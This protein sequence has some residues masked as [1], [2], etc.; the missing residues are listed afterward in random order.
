[1]FFLASGKMLR[2]AVLSRNDEIWDETCQHCGKEDEQAVL[3]ENCPHVCCPR[4]FARDPHAE[5]A[6]VNETDYYCPACRG[7]CHAD[8]TRRAC[9]ESCDGCLLE[10]ETAQQGGAAL[11]LHRQDRWVPATVTAV[12]APYVMVTVAGERAVQVRLT[13]AN[14]LVEMGPATLGGCFT[15]WRLA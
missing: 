8:G 10:H 1:V 2:T 11:E 12:G 9:P 13:L 4:C 5:L 7:D 15:G 3:C 6:L 14:Y